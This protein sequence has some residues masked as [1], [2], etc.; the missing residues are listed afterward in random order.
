MLRGL[1]GQRY[2]NVASAPIA[3]VIE[4]E[5][6]AHNATLWRLQEACESDTASRTDAVAR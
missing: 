4:I 2:R 3:E 6:Q 5:A 1:A